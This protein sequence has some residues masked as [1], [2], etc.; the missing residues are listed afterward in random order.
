MLRYAFLELILASA[1]LFAPEPLEGKEPLA[2]T[3]PLTMSGDLSA[4]MVAGIDRYATR[5]TA[6][7][8]EGRERFWNRDHSSKEAYAKSIEPNRKR[9]RAILGAVDGRIARP[10]LEVVAP[11]GQSATVA[12]TDSF[13]VLA[14]RWPVFELVRGEGL[15]V[16]PKA[17]PAARVVV[18]PD[19]DHTP[20]MSLGIAD[21]C[22]PDLQLARRFAEAGC[23][24]VV[25]VLIDRKCTWSGNPVLGR[26]TNQPHR[27]FLYRQ[28]FELGRHLLGIE[29]QKVEAALDALADGPNG[30]RGPLV[31]AG[32]G[33]GGLVALFAAALDPRV[34]LAI[35]SGCF[36][37]RE[38]VWQEPI[39]RNVFGFLRE[40]G[41]AEVASL[42][43]PRGLHVQN[44]PGPRVDGPP[45]PGPGRGGGAA[46]GR[47][48]DV[49][50][51]AEAVEVERL[52]SLVGKLGEG[53]PTRSVE[54][55][56][57]SA[58]PRFA[59]LLA[60]VDRSDPPSRRAAA[61]Q[62][63][64]FNPAE[65]QKRQFLEIQEHLQKILRLCEYDRAKEWAK[66]PPRRDVDWKAATRQKREQF[67]N[68]VIGKLPETETPLQPRTRKILDRPRWTAYEVVLG[69]HPDVFAWGY[70][71]VPKDIGP[72][73]RRPVVVCQHGLEGLPEDTISEDPKGRGY[74]YY[75]AF[76]ARLAERG[77]VTFAP[78]NPYRGEDKFR[79]L[80]RKLNPLGRTLFSVIVD[81]HERILDFLCA[82]PFVD[83]ER[84]GFYG[85]SYGGKTAMRVPAMLDRYCLSICSADFNEWVKKNAT[86]DSNYSYVF[87][88]EYEI[89]EW[90]LAHTFNYAEMAYLIAPRPFMVERG[91]D[92]GV[93]PDE[94]VAYEYAKIRRQYQKLGIADR[95]EIEFFDGPHSIHAQGTFRF[96]HRHLNWPEK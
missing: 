39:Y 43:F 38:G 13:R 22:P 82:Q 15:W 79:V 10:R 9:L 88:G 94:W 7:S 47:L 89:F 40:F 25:P 4:P 54:R 84:I 81:Q 32:H 12:E 11:V 77:F 30:K 29:V 87:S 28:G 53:F 45:K 18:V 69:V 62:R 8:I 16:E 56:R 96:L 86:V 93:A 74:P 36:G 26:M 23:E 91:H 72:G 71:L 46:P 20:E 17:A 85:L 34:E 37:P 65:R 3:E 83:P 14:V 51:D 49:T 57:P 52:R 80:Q 95:T 27:E 55:G 92:D 5:L 1:L 48:R 59:G 58:D 31:V 33:E 35:L 90:D 63:K 50:L 44:R 73:E 41:D 66:I 75:K 6:A 78:H 24:V 60:A 76:A 19:A 68:E 42:V 64:D 70:L 21:G 61:D 67:W 2:G